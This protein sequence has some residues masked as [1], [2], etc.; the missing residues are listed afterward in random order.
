M[1]NYRQ[2][3]IETFEFLKDYLVNL[4]D[5]SLAEVNRLSLR[6][7]TLFMDSKEFMELLIKNEKR[8]ILNLNTSYERSVIL[9]A[10]SAVVNSISSHELF[11]RKKDYKQ[12]PTDNI[13]KVCDMHIRT[14]GKYYLRNY[15]V[16][17]HFVKHIRFVDY[18]IIN[19]RYY[20]MKGIYF[21]AQSCYIT[22]ANLFKFETIKMIFSDVTIRHSEFSD[23]KFRNG[24][25]RATKFE[26]C[27]FTKVT[28]ENITFDNVVF[29]ISDTVN[30][31]F[32]N[33][34]FVEC[35]FEN[36]II[37]KTLY[38]QNYF[39]IDKVTGSVYQILVDNMLDSRSGTDG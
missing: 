28:F 20:Y 24:L 32:I 9:A 34:K 21:N 39:S 19:L 1:G 37:D 3:E 29:G 26:Y 16:F 18:D 33:C 30:I 25:L 4:D 22:N 13:F 2:L 38:N 31:S 35:Y 6:K 5:E 17:T 27:S 23:C 36:I 7:T 14:M 8:K 10:L 12:V 15:S 11:I